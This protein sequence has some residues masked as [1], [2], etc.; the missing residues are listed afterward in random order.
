MCYDIS[1]AAPHH[2]LIPLPSALLILSPVDLLLQPEYKVA[3]PICTFLFSVFVLG[4]TITI[5][6]DVFR[7]LME[8]KLNSTA[9]SVS[10]A[11]T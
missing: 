7:V 8:G 10:L 5:L 6:R 9:F 1:R 4:T 2:H 3:D 11:L